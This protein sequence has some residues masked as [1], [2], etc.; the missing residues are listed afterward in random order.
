MKERIGQANRKVTT[1]YDTAGKRQSRATRDVR[2]AAR[3]RLL[4]IAAFV[5]DVFVGGWT[6]MTHVGSAVAKP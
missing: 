6:L 4:G 2:W 5:V 1:Q 3:V